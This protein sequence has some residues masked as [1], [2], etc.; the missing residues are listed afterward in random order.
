MCCSQRYFYLIVSE[1]AVFFRMHF[2]LSIK[3]SHITTLLYNLKHAYTYR[4]DAL[5]FCYN[6]TIIYI[7]SPLFLFAHLVTDFTTV[8]IQYGKRAGNKD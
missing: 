5:D 7:S 6:K 2:F 3:Q 1:M 4:T 8:N